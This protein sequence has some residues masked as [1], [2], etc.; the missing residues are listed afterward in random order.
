MFQEAAVLK[1]GGNGGGYRDGNRNRS[2]DARGGGDG[3]NRDRNR[4]GRNRD[5]NRDRNRDGNR[6]RN[7]DGGSRGRRGEGQGRPGSSNG[8]GERKHHSRPQAYKRECPLRAFSF[9]SIMCILH[10]SYDRKGLLY[11]CKAWL[12]CDECTF[13]ECISISNDDVCTVSEIR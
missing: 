4:D 13:E 8:R 10:N 11:A 5:G 9:I 1:R 2:R 3:R 12:R 7:R 6:D